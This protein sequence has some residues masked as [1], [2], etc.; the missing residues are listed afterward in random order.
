MLSVW[1][2]ASGSNKR[3][4]WE[5]GHKMLLKPKLTVFLAFS[6]SYLA[7]SVSPGF[8]PSHLTCVWWSFVSGVP[9][10]EKLVRT[11]IRFGQNFPG[12]ME[13]RAVCFYE[14]FQAL[15]LDAVFFSD[16][17]GVRESFHPGR[18]WSVSQLRFYV[19]NQLNFCSLYKESVLWLRWC[20]W[21]LVWE[22]EII[23][24]HYCLCSL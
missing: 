1:C 9:I 12:R 3:W 20:L 22:L 10:V 17:W 18:G 16:N 23:L 2:Y 4:D 19:S 21:F 5:N 14:E 13:R 15:C 8:F 6:A 11:I 7:W 24:H